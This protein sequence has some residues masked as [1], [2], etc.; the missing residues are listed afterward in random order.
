MQSNPEE[1]VPAD[2]LLKI[3]KI[4]PPDEY[5]KIKFNVPYWIILDVIQE[6]ESEKNAFT[7]KDI[8][9]LIKLRKKKKQIKYKLALAASVSEVLDKLAENHLIKEG[10]KGSYV[11]ETNVSGVLVEF[12]GSG[13]RTRRGRLGFAKYMANRTKPAILWYCLCH[14]NSVQLEAVKKLSAYLGKITQ[15][16]VSNSEEWYLTKLVKKGYLKRITAFEFMLIGEFGEKKIF[17]ELLSKYKVFV[18]PEPLLRDFIQ[19]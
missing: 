2:L 1:P 13:N 15:R 14:G 16:K 3:L 18:E 19:K 5:T 4:F 10:P 6:L 8:L 7:S 12:F 9:Q 17:D 11:F